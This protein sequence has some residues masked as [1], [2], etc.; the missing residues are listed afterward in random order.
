[1]TRPSLV[2]AALLIAVMLLCGASASHASADD[3]AAVAASSTAATCSSAP[4]NRTD[5]GYV[6]IDQAQCVAKACCW[7]PSVCNQA[8]GCPDVCIRSGCTVFVSNAI[9]ADLLALIGIV[10]VPHPLCS[11]L[12]HHRAVLCVHPPCVHTVRSRT[13]VVLRGQRY[14]DAAAARAQLRRARIPTR[15]RLCGRQSGS[16]PGT[17]G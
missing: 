8:Q 3:Q 5:C 14:P 2:G 4:V 9:N 17:S 15:L 7:V 13:A 16:V 11:I 1:M 6:G 10:S 12:S